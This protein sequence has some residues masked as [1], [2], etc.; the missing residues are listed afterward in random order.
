MHLAIDP[1]MQEFIQN[2]LRSGQYSSAEDV[3][4]AAF[5]ALKQQEYLGDFRPGELEAL[6]AEGEQSISGQETLEAEDALRIRRQGRNA[7]GATD[8]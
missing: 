8:G 3:V 6:L 1:D 2:K 7:P 4:R 5:A